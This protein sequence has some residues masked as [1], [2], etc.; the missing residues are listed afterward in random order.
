MVVVLFCGSPLPLRGG[1]AYEAP[2]NVPALANALVREYGEC[3]I[4]LVM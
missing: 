3:I 2:A 4:V 1:V